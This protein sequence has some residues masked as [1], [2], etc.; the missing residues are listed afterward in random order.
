MKFNKIAIAAAAVVSASALVLAGCASGGSGGD[1]Q[2]ADNKDIKICVY[3][4]GDG[5]TFWSVF[6]KGAEAAATMTGV[7]LDYQGTTNDAAKLAQ[8]I[9]AGVAGGCSAISVSVPDAGAESEA[10]AAAEAAGIPVLT[11]NSGAK[12]YKALGAYT[13]VG[14]DEVVAGEAAGERFNE[15]GLTNVVCAIQEANNS[16][17]AERCQ[18]LKNT[19]A[20]TVTDLNIDGA[21]AD[22]AMAEQKIT[23]ALSADPTIDG[24]FLLNADVATGS[25]MPAVETSGREIVIGTV[26]MSA[27]ALQAIKDGKIAFAIDQQ[28]YAQGFLAV[29]LQYLAVTNGNQLGGGLPMY[30]GPGFV[31]S[32]NVDDVITYIGN[33]TR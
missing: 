27:D 16:G 25:A 26:D 33:G 3:T 2:A 30:T 12:D 8:A 17:L 13:H 10:L 19:F 18:G 9:E 22:P 14:Q 15:L 5:G 28:Q 21:L 24:L 31:T 32:D 20:G 7:T 1:S 6:E 4:H 23:A 29:M 11:T